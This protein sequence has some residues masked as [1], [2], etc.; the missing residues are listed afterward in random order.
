MRSRDLTA[1][2][3]F[4]VT[5]AGAAGPVVLHAAALDEQG[6]IRRVVLEQSLVSWADVVER[7][8][9]REQL[10]SAVPGVLK[11]YDLPDLAARLEPCPLE[12]RQPSERGGPARLAEELEAAYSPAIHGLRNRRGAR[13]PRRSLTTR[14]PQERP[15]HSTPKPRTF[16]SGS[17]R[18]SCRPSRR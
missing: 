10:G 8:I 13:P 7:G 3:G 4:E 1:A 18:P 16:S 15:C 12:I 5:G 2:S 11:F 9:S 14:D 6:L 17:P